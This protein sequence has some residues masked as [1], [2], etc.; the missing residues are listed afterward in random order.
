MISTSTA[1]DFGLKFKG[2]GADKAVEFHNAKFK[3]KFHTS[4]F[5]D[6]NSTQQNFKTQNSTI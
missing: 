1:V 4:E 6:A 3:A 5:R 2:L